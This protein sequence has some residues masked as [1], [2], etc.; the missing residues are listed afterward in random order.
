MAGRNYSSSRLSDIIDKINETS[1][2]TLRQVAQLS[3]SSSDNDNSP[4]ALMQL[5]DDS[6]FTSSTVAPFPHPPHASS[7]K[8][9]QNVQPGHSHTSE[10][11]SQYGF[12]AQQPYTMPQMPTNPMQS[13]ARHAYTYD[14]VAPLDSIIKGTSLAQTSHT[15]YETTLAATANNFED[16][17]ENQLSRFTAAEGQYGFHHTQMR[18]FEP[19]N[20]GLARGEPVGDE[21]AVGEPCAQMSSGEKPAETATSSSHNDA[22]PNA[23]GPAVAH[24]TSLA[25][26]SPGPDG[27]HF[28]DR[29]TASATMDFQFRENLKNVKDDDVEDVKRNT[30][31]HVAKLRNAFKV[32]GFMAPPLQRNATGSTTIP[33]GAQEH[34]DWNQWQQ[35]AQA[36]VDV[37]L[38]QK[39][40]DAHAESRAWEIFDEI[41]KVH[42]MGFRNT[43]QTK[44]RKSKCSK[45]IA[46]ADR[47]IREYALVRQKLLDGDKIMD[48]ACNP[49]GYADTTVR[50]MTNN[51]SRARKQ[52]VSNNT[53]NKPDG[54][55]GAVKAGA[56]AKRYNG[57]KAVAKMKGPKAVKE[58]SKD[59]AQ[60]EGEGHDQEASTDGQV[61]T[62][63]T[64]AAT[65]ADSETAQAD[66]QDGDHQIFFDAS[67]SR[68]SDAPGSPDQEQDEEDEDLGS[69]EPQQSD[70]DNSSSHTPLARE[71]SARLD[72]DPAPT[73]SSKRAST[74]AYEHTSATKKRKL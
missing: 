18:D 11:V 43:K 17:P 70:D 28:N 25:V 31:V 46:E 10:V 58:G 36:V 73:R 3:H 24:Q 1:F 69:D 13:F 51:R 72:R 56:I 48:F 32:K 5:E 39:Y 12:S 62:T 35:G 8:P 45:R 54:R 47:V 14:F 50:S 53:G 26:P 19:A 21:P 6:L 30:R 67:G 16:G 4:V 37:H 44:D 42:T 68:M 57:S 27:L 29:V 55:R 59:V 33:T 2:E 20:D 49:Q 40:A 41:V 64:P 60:A 38:E 61:E 9:A 63:E 71:P 23:N 52:G 74:G 7:P 66:G 22:A 34:L 65:K 15:A